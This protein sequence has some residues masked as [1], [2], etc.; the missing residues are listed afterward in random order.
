MGH[1]A[2][3]NRDHFGPL[4]EEAPGKFV[5]D[6]HIEVCPTELVMARSEGQFLEILSGKVRAASQHVAAEVQRVCTA[7]LW[8][9]LNMGVDRGQHV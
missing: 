5:C 8:R 9:T 4:I 7:S 1:I 3:I 6:F 2:R